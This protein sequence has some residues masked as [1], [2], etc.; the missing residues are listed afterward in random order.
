M[1]AWCRDFDNWAICDTICFHL[2]DRTPHAWAKVGHW[3]RRRRE[4]VKRA[5]FALLAA[6]ALHDKTAPDSRFHTGLGLVERAADRRAQL[7][8][9]GGQLG[10]ALDRQAQS[11]AARRRLRA[12]RAPGASPSAAARWVGK[13]ALRE[14]TSAAVL[15]RLAARRPRQL[16]PLRS[17]SRGAPSGPCCGR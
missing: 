15:R 9:E 17:R 11:H 13:D 16:T 1:D 2:F 7:R 12:R 6:L 4:F 8:Q 3:A 10:A 5:A 14:L